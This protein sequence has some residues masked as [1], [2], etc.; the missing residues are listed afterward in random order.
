[1]DHLNRIWIYK[2]VSD[3]YYTDGNNVYKKIE[4]EK[5]A[6]KHR[7]TCNKKRYVICK[8][9]CNKIN[10]LTNNK[11]VFVGNNLYKEMKWFVDKDGYEF[12]MVDVK[13]QP[14][15]ISHHRLVYFFYN[16]VTVNLKGL[17]VDHIDRNRK[18]NNIN[19]LRL[20][21]YKMNSN[22]IDKNNRMQKSSKYIYECMDIITNNVIAKGMANVISNAIGISSIC[23]N[24]YAKYH[25]V[26]HSR[27]K[28]KIIEERGN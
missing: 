1:M 4:K 13:K 10:N 3:Y 18:N 2:N 7:I 27:Y 25:Y 23:I 14:T 8:D 16:N 12:L 28:I 11:Y 19:N 22:N 26:Y 6:R 5:H 21:T 9:N 15:K 20:V 17:V 24:R